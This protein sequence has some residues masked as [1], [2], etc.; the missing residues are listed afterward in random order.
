MRNQNPGS[1]KWK[2]LK[3]VV[4]SAL[5]SHFEDARSNNLLQVTS[6]PALTRESGRGFQGTILDGNIR[7]SSWEHQPLCLW[8]EH[9]A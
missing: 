7:H 3:Q 4:L 1:E 8:R 5:Q 6:G 9:T 2:S